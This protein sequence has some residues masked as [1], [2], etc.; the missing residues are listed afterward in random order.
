MGRP[1]IRPAMIVP[2]DRSYGLMACRSVAEL[3]TIIVT[4]TP[5]TKNSLPSRPSRI[6]SVQRPRS[7][8]PDAWT[9]LPQRPI[10][11]PLTMIPCRPRHLSPPL[12]TPFMI[13]TIK[14]GPRRRTIMS[15][16]LHTNSNTRFRLPRPH[17]VFINT[18]PRTIAL[19]S[20]AT[21]DDTA[22]QSMPMCSPTSPLHHP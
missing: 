19:T 8:I 14:S 21:N 1:P 7:P 6:R 17:L 18:Q 16:H 15:G 3:N 2:A 9:S 11:L 12:L 5:V 13:R 20:S 10:R 4:V 22:S